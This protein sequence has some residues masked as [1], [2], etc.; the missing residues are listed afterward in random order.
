M[1]GAPTF[2]EP[3]ARERIAIIGG[4]MSA[5]T[6]AYFLTDPS[7]G[8]RYQVSVYTMGWR[9]GGKGA[10]GRNAAL[11]DRIEEHGLHI[12]FGTYHNAIALM[13]RCYAE[14]GRPAGAP[15]ATF[16]EAFKGQRR[17]V[18]TETVGGAERDWPIDFPD[19]P[20]LGHDQTV[21]T[22]LKRL[23]GWILDR[24]RTIR[25]FDQIALSGLVAD[26]EAARARLAAGLAGVAIPAT[27]RVGHL[28]DGLG[29]SLPLLDGRLVREFLSGELKLLARALWALLSP[30]LPAD[31]LARRS[32]I[33]VYLAVTVARGI[34]DDQLVEK[35]FSTVD[36]EELRAWLGRHSS[37]DGETA[38]E[39]DPLA[40]RSPCIQAFYDASF[41]YADGDAAQPNIAA[42]VGLRGILR[43]ML[44][45][46]GSIIL[47]MQAGMGDTVF[48]PLYLVL[49]AR[50]VSF[51]FFH[52]LTG[53]TLDGDGRG[54][55]TLEL[56]R[57]VALNGAEYQPLVTVRDLAC[58][59][60]EPDYVQI[61]DG[62]RL[63][64]SGANLE[65]W[66]S[67]WTDAGASLTLR[68]DIDFSRVVLAI[69][70]SVLPQVTAPLRSNPRWAAMLAGLGV[71]DTVSAQLWFAR[72]RQ[73]LGR[74]GPAD[75]IGG[76]IEPWSSL[77]DFTHLL[78]RE[79]WP[80][81][82]GP[83][84]LYYTCGPSKNA[85]PPDDAG[86]FDNL[87]SFLQAAGAPLWPAAGAVGA[88]DWDVLWA[89]AGAVG[90]DR[91]RAQYWRVNSDPTEQ[92]VIAS[93]GTSA[94]RLRADQTGFDNLLIAGEW[95]DTAVNI[96][97]IE[98][99]A[100]A[101]MRASRAI[102]GVPQTIIGE[103]DL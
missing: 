53:M 102:C 85:D 55:A 33:L 81:V 27:R 76:Y 86:V 43:I 6:A 15:L 83:A 70:Y 13:R 82:G 3:G 34:I 25:G 103:T 50:G 63:K 22:L 48:T 17:V 89:P 52:R 57:Q 14:L 78:P 59:P 26:A 46:T 66:N 77:S 5:L 40:F 20:V 62:A 67:G 93:A 79:S 60:A 11:H 99:T 1:S 75:I 58:W 24:S 30:L 37:F 29:G 54:I 72:T 98:S 10:S 101:G 35:G 2:S 38:R 41:S 69:S 92:Y 36:G 28:L 90:E 9:L 23:V 47:E 45:Y 91:L 84:C 4:G 32:W 73:A 64:A 71:T 65:H 97:A 95:V 31:D 100:M 7:L 61:V 80:L 56:S 88:F 19:V 12:W 51:N 94:A 42:G 16:D 8:G 39:A 68:R 74:S 21:L 18:L 49:K 44:D 87:R 96:S